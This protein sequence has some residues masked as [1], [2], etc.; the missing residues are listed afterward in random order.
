MFTPCI[1]FLPVNYILA[2]TWNLEFIIHIKLVKF[3]FLGIDKKPRLTVCLN[4]AFGRFIDR[5]WYCW[6]ILVMLWKNWH[7]WKLIVKIDNY[8][9][10]A[11]HANTSNRRFSSNISSFLNTF[12]AVRSMKVTAVLRFVPRSLLVISCQLS[13]RVYIHIFFSFNI[14]TTRV[15][16]GQS[17]RICTSVGYCQSFQSLQNI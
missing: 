10:I 14:R 17:E 4:R 16:H 7:L 2:Y 9:A 1:I 8:E 6:T 12:P 13:L 3:N 15:K 5:R 11:K